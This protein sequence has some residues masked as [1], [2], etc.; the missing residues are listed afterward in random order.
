MPIYKSR[1][2]SLIQMFGLFKNI[3]F[4]LITFFQIN[5]YHLGLQWVN[6]LYVTRNDIKS[7]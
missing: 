1:F 7:I 3:L 5:M 4:Y 6:N 2:K